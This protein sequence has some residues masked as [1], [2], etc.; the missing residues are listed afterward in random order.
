MYMDGRMDG[1]WID[2]L[3]DLP[4]CLYCGRD[5]NLSWGAEGSC[6]GREQRPGISTYII[7][8]FRTNLLCLAEME[9]LVSVLFSSRMALWPDVA[10]WC[11]GDAIR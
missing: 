2:V 5:H 3:A 8:L 11:G 7:P 4:S 10:W 1:G 9:S 6:G